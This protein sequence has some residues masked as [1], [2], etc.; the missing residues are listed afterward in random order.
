MLAAVFLVQPLGQLSAYATGYFALLGIANSHGLSHDETNHDIAAPILDIVWRI[1]I[2]VG[3]LTSLFAIVLR[4]TIP[5]TPRWLLTTKP[6]TA[7][8][9]AW[10]VFTDGYSCRCRRIGHR[11]TGNPGTEL[12]NMGNRGADAGTS[13]LASQDTSDQESGDDAELEQN[14][15]STQNSDLDAE[16]RRFRRRESPEIQVLSLPKPA[17][18][19]VRTTVTEE[20]VPEDQ[21]SN[22]S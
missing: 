1:V 4:I 11:E 6:K 5:E 19:E 12:T 3:A 18:D 2:G 7:L 20:N 14:G 10:R 8:Q 17:L 22:A 13:L 16:H 9:S 15:T 21:G